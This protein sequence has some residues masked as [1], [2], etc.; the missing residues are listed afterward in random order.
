MIVRMAPMKIQPFVIIVI[1]IKIHNTNV[2]MANVYRNFGIVILMMIVVIIRM[3]QHIYAVIEIVVPDG[4]N[5]HQDIIIVAYQVGYSVMVKMIV[6]IILMKQIQNYVQYVILRVILNVKM[7][8]VFHCVGD[9]VSLF[10]IF[11]L[12]FIYLYCILL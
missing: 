5:V 3:N 10:F 4:E 2:I 7:I 6:A 9:A 8:A 12:K 11:I 1:V